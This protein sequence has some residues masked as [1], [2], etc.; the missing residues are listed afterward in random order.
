[1]CARVGEP[2]FIYLLVGERNL[3]TSIYT[4]GWEEAAYNY[5]YW[6]VG[7]TCIFHDREKEQSTESLS[8]KYI[9]YINT[10]KDFC[11]HKTFKKK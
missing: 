11:V 5:I 9:K 6:L 1:M 8:G 7:G 3:H 2:V 10:L 4:G